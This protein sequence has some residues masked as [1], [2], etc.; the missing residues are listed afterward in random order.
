[1][2][3]IWT[4]CTSISPAPLLSPDQ[5]DEADDI[6]LE[7]LRALL[8][9]PPMTPERT[10]NSDDNELSYANCA[11]INDEQR[12]ISRQHDERP[13]HPVHVLSPPQPRRKT[14]EFPCFYCNG[15]KHPRYVKCA[16][17]EHYRSVYKSSLKGQKYKIGDILR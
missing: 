10:T 3:W 5:P 16:T 14:T 2:R 6:M 15:E 11:A 9:S 17:R 8:D 7:A 4:A 13:M 12:K 1:M